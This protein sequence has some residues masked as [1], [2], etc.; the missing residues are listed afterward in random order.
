MGF[1]K[2]RPEK[3]V[4]DIDI[5]SIINEDLDNHSS[6][7]ESE[8]SQDFSGEGVTQTNSPRPKAP[9]NNKSNGNT[10]PV[11]QKTIII[12]CAAI[13]LAL[14]A[15]TIGIASSKSKTTKTTSVQPATVTAQQQTDS[16]KKAGIDNLQ[17]D[18]QHKNTSS[19]ESSDNLTTDL[20]GKPVPSDYQIKTIKTVTEVVGYTKHRVVLGNGLEFYYL[21][22]DYKGQPYKVQIPFAMFKELSSDT[23]YVVVDAEDT[24]TT[25][26]QEIITYM[27]VRKDQKSYLDKV[28]K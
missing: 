18:T 1:D 20:N 11:N 3:N 19:V 23:G 10:A 5:D 21:D 24:T 16:N 7:S 27:A 12:G 6:S 26:N 22:V 8:S 9:R 28:G 25:T 14:L 13:V 15:L 4:N 2:S 17:S